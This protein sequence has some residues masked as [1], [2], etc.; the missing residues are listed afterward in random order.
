MGG[1]APILDCPPT[2][3]SILCES[4]PGGI[5]WSFGS[6]KGAK[7]STGV[8]IWPG[9][10]RPTS[11]S[12]SFDSGGIGWSRDLH[13][14]QKNMPVSLPPLVRSSL[15]AGTRPPVDYHQVMDGSVSGDWFSDSVREEW[16]AAGR[17]KDGRVP[18]LLAPAAPQGW[19]HDEEL[20]LPDLRSI[21]AI[22]KECRSLPEGH[23]G[24]LG[25]QWLD[26]VNVWADRMKVK[27]QGG[28]AKVSGSWRL[29]IDAW[30]KRL[31]RLPRARRL[32]VL[33]II[34]HGATLPFQGGLPPKK[35]I[36]RLQNHPRL[37]E[38]SHEVWDT[39]REQLDES[40]VSPYDCGASVP[41]GAPAG[42]T[43]QGSSDVSI[44]PKGIYPIRW[45][46]KSN[47]DRVRITIN[48]IPLNDSLEEGSGAVD[49]STLSKMSSLWQKDDYQISLD[50]HAA[51]YHLEYNEDAT[52]WVGFM[53]DDSELPQ[54]A[55]EELTKRCPQARWG[56]SKWV[57]TYKG[58]AM[59]CSPSAAQYC[60]CVDALMDTWR[61]CTV[62]QAQGLP[63]EQLR[64]SQYIDDSL[65]MVQGFA[66]SM[67]L[68]LRVVLEHI[69][70]G[71][72]INVD[73]SHLLPSRRR[74]FLG[75][76]CDST[77]L[78]F[79]LTPERC[80][81]LRLRIRQLRQAVQAARQA[82]GP[83]VLVEMRAIA[84]VV[85]SIWSIHVVC[86]KA[87]AI[88]CRS[89]CE[90][91]A[92]QLRLDHLR[93]ERDEFRLKRLLQAVWD[94]V[95]VWSSEAEEE[96][97]FWE[98]VAFDS[99]KAP[100]SFDA[101]N[102]DVKAFV[103]NPSRGTLS[104][105]VKVFCADSSDHATG[106][107]IFTPGLD[108]QWVA[109]DTMF[110]NLSD[111]AI[112]QSS[113]YAELEGILKAD[114]SLVPDDCKFV[115]AICDNQSV[116]IILKSGSR[117][118][119]LQRLVVAVFKRCLRLGRI[120]VPVWQRRTQHIVRVADLGS[121][122]VDHC[123]FSL[124]MHLFWRAN[125]CAR[126]LFGRGFQ[127]DRF[128]SFDT[129]MPTDGR[130]KLPFNSYYMQPF[131][132]GRDALRQNWVGWVNWAHP[133]HHLVGR[134]ISLMRR[135][136]A[137]GAVVLPLGSR[138]LW[139][140]AAQVGAEGVVHQFSFDPRAPR[141]RLIGKQTPCAWRGRFAVVF[142]DFRRYRRPF[143]PSPSAEHLHAK[144]QAESSLP[145]HKL[146][147]V[148]TPGFLSGRGTAN[149][150]R[151]VKCLRVLR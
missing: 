123:N 136:Q 83:R 16:L 115:F 17:S 99:L 91:L 134:T 124:P 126:K 44:L 142:F 23:M 29:N 9:P 125:Q 133:P 31:A 93:N 19:L 87:V 28:R 120:L 41:L 94:G 150:N 73:K 7:D 22:E 143:R 61:N 140:S 137:V 100:M 78:S 119:L 101:L 95:A 86:H 104:R 10:G 25:R 15:D 103:L 11:R 128:S 63:P 33:N 77:D 79:S 62:G 57:F 74:R 117:R 13:R 102:E 130:R 112:A 84:G 35:P 80:A 132:S 58:L 90:V 81:K 82:K 67:E 89:M 5:G 111:M 6:H 118:P 14:R 135:Q 55:V 76:V 139:A 68:G 88:M 69:I 107:A 24:P 49:L 147:F 46:E 50:Q 32:K 37:S 108:G 3:D 52:E 129:A 114:L 141:N 109:T 65:Y 98:S 106:A 121:R 59:G 85:G 30:R 38:K 40:A 8:S 18:R 72:H 122:V 47:S 56:T 42:T 110:A 151:Y 1:D 145:H 116:T 51:Y 149:T 105:G 127:F 138:Q 43:P 75:C 71:F 34:E 53:V 148:M 131:S 144:S 113:T 36:R 48:M 26:E 70:C 66:H 4:G 2:S 60:L 97:T 45:V 92:S 96:L 20:P 21:L 146:L 39:L 54:G 27:Y 12:R 64:C